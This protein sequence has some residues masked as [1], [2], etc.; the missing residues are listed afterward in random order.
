MRFKIGAP[1]VALLGIVVYILHL[2]ISRDLDLYIHPRYNAFTLG[3][4]GIG[5]GVIIVQVLTNGV[6]HKHDNGKW[7]YLPLVII[8]GGALLLPARS[9]SS[10][11]VTQRSVGSVSSIASADEQPLDLLFSGSSKGLKLADWARI[12]E[13]NSDESYYAQKTARVSGFIYDADL[14]DDTVWL[15]R[16]VVT[17]CAVDA[18]P[19]GVPVRLDGWRSSYKQDQ[20]L[21]VEGEFKRV[22]TQKGSQLVLIPSSLE[23]INQPDDPYAN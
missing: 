1:L 20:W 8:L 3:M 15:A 11:T 21:E 4:V 13:T 5:L 18:Q 7:S 17:C 14:G 22:E 19:V 16:F 6:S 12:L 9:L 2:G 23:S 10:A